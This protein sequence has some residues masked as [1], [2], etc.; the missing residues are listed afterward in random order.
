MFE[1]D[2]ANAIEEL[3]AKD[4]TG[5]KYGKPKRVAQEKIRLEMNK[6]EQSQISI[7]NQLDSLTSLTS[8]VI[9]Q[10]P[11]QPEILEWRAK[12]VTIQSCIVRYGKHIE[13]MVNPLAARAL[14]RFTL[15][16]GP[17]DALLPAAEEEEDK[18]RQ[19]S[20][21][22]QLGPLGEQKEDKPFMKFVE[23]IEKIIKIGNSQEFEALK[24]YFPKEYEFGTIEQEG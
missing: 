8:S 9:D 4:G 23:D 18:K 6:C 15:Q 17:S 1:K 14:P 16:E 20:E 19:E 22:K 13:A 12:L 2:Y 7:D 24:Q 3:S 21:L 5:K 10:Y 11:H